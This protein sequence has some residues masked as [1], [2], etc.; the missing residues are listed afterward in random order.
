MKTNISFSKNRKKMVVNWQLYVMLATPLFF[1]ILFHYVPMYG[2]QMAFK[3][4]NIIDGITGSPW[5]GF[6]YFSKFITD[7]QFVRVIS[8]TLVISI[9]SMLVSFPCSII[10][11]IALNYLHSE[12]YRK[13]AQTVSYAPYLIS[14]VVMC[15]TILQLLAPRNG[16]ITSAI[17]SIFHTDINFLGV[18]SYF[19]DIYVWS[20]VWQ[21][22]GFNAII[23][24]ATLIGIDPEL[25]EA[26]ITD[27]ASKMQR[28][29]FIDLPFLIPTVVKLLI[30]NL[31]QVLNIGYEKVLLLQNNLNIA[32]SEVISTYVY[33]VGLKS[34]I[35]QYSYSTAIG[36]FQS[37]IGIVLIIAVNKIANKVSDSGIW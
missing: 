18:S 23:Y 10:F 27:G 12:K 30:L 22:T 6:K 21:S 5:A 8:N 3:D 19:D 13:F 35:P 9:Y 37:I 31:G 28:I 1:L 2:V 16:L 26:A 20:G 14:T 25:H 11:A 4:F 32:N 7:Y 17:N 15:S 24:I 29:L 34:M 33:K 36:L